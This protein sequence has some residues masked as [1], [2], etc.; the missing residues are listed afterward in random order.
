MAQKTGFIR[1]AS[2]GIEAGIITAILA[3]SNWLMVTAYK[4]N[5]LHRFESKL[6]ASALSSNI[7][8]EARM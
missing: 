6:N 4:Q 3:A 8:A 1:G 7:T 2:R 5:A